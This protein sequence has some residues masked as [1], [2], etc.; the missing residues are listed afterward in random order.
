LERRPESQ[1][2]R[3]RASNN[4]PADDRLDTYSRLDAFDRAFLQADARVLAG[5][6]EA[7]RGALAGPVVAAAVILPPL[8]GLIGVNDSKKLKEAEREEYFDQIIEIAISIG[9]AQGTP[10]RID[11]DNILNATLFAMA[12]AVAKLTV[13]PDIVLVDGRDTIYAGGRVIPV[14]RGDGKS[15]AVASASIVA[16]VMRDRTMRRLH[17]RHPE[18]NFTKN[19]GYGTKEHRQAILKYGIL[20]QHRKTFTMKGIEKN[21]GMF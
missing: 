12:G 6:D 11:R 15:L 10:R 17:R 13:E 2:E 3:L 16:K 21:A 9:I 5:V 1:N 20:P 14:T 18:Y 8:S 7:G 4:A 19:K